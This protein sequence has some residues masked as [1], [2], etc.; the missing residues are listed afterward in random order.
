VPLDERAER[1][2][3]AGANLF[4][5]GQFGRLHPLI[6][7]SRCGGVRRNFDAPAGRWR[8][9]SIRSRL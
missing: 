6:R 3:I 7:L 2:G 9:L 5:G 8:H 1:V 4:E